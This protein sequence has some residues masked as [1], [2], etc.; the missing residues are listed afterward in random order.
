MWTVQVKMLVPGR[1]SE[2]ETW[3][4][5]EPMVEGQEA[6]LGVNQMLVESPVGPPHITSSFCANFSHLRNDLNTWVPQIPESWSKCPLLLMPGEG[7]EGQRVGRYWQAPRGSQKTRAALWDWFLCFVWEGSTGRV[8]WAL[9]G[10]VCLWNVGCSRSLFHTYPCPPEVLISIFS[11][12]CQP[13]AVELACFLSLS[14]T[15]CLGLIWG[16]VCF[17]TL[18]LTEVQC[19]S[20]RGHEEPLLSSCLLLI[21]ATLLC[22]P[23][24]WEMLS[25][26]CTSSS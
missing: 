18:A 10:V 24:P 1:I 3:Q 20:L 6:L 25:S 13:P 23:S 2:E 22:K 5:G 11:E 4:P 15:S 14:Q 12:C 9:G 26:V 21:L 17:E 19:F 8:L 7:G 16:L